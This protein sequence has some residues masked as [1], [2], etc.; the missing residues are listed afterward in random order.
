MRHATPTTTTLL[1]GTLGLLT[2][3]ALALGPV[4]CGFGGDGLGFPGDDNGGGNAPAAPAGTDS[5]SNAPPAP[6]C[7]STG[8]AYTTFDGSSLTGSRVHA[9]TGADRSRVK[10]YS[11]LATEYPRVL[12]GTSPALLD[13]AAATFGESPDRWSEEPQASAVMLYT[14]YRVAFQGCLAATKDD[15]KYAAAPT[16]ATASTECAAMERKFWSRTATPEETS[17]CAAFA[18]TGTA[19]ETDPRRR[20]AYTCASV[21]T[22]AGFLT[23]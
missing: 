3:L 15:A 21:L 6:L 9:A 7:A 5:T 17:A 11:A 1:G 16:D 20:W 2:A 19:K 22:A 13:G 4:G 18:T 12:G 8:K 14:A 23:D 10:P